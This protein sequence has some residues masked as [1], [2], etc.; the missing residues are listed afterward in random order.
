MF[1]V[2]IGPGQDDSDRDDW[3]D[4]YDDYGRQD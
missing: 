4:D 2:S 3:D 1:S